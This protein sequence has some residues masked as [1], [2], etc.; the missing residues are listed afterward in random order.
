MTI[1]TKLFEECWCPCEGFARVCL[2]GSD[3]PKEL[4]DFGK[5]K[6]GDDY[7]GSC[8]SINIIIENKVPTAAV[9]SYTAVDE[10]W[11]YGKCD[12]YME[13]WE[14]YKAHVSNEELEET[15]K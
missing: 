10:M 6:D 14:Y 5:E 12:N 2:K 1:N 3:I 4:E 15:I 7:D 13:A 11:D 9:I 8:F